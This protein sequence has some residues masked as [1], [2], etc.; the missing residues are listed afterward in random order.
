VKW[1]LHLLG[2][3]DTGIRLPL[4]PMSEMHRGELERRLHAVGV[5]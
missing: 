3:I 4:L 2:R 5:L 1:A